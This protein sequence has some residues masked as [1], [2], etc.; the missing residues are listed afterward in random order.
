MPYRRIEAVKI[1]MNECVGREINEA[2]VKR[3]GIVS[4]LVRVRAAIDCSHT[5][6][7]DL[8][9]LARL[10][11]ADAAINEA[12]EIQRPMAGDGGSEFM[13]A[14]PGERRH[15]HAIEIAAC[16]LIGG[17]EIRVSIEPHDA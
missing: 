4:M 13:P 6:R 9:A 8:L 3:V 11:I 17:I 5:I 1:D 12:G 7:F 16:Q 10:E 15:A 2:G 14:L